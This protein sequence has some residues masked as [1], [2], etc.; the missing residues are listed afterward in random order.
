MI[1]PLVTLSFFSD[2]ADA[3]FIPFRLCYIIRFQIPFHENEFSYLQNSAQIRTTGGS[4][5]AVRERHTR[6]NETSS[7][8]IFFNVGREITIE[9]RRNR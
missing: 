3:V 9:T 4:I 8:F 7:F 1:P 6:E 2:S 5:R